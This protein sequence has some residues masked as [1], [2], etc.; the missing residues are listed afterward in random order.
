MDLIESAAFIICLDDVAPTSSTA[1]ANT[2]LLDNISNRWS[3]KSLQFVICRNGSSALLCEHSMVDGST[4]RQLNEAIVDAIVAHS[5]EPLWTGAV[6]LRNPRPVVSKHVFDPIPDLGFHI[7]RVQRKNNHIFAFPEHK[8][9]LST[10]FGSKLL[11]SKKCSPKSGYQLVIQ[12]ASL[13]YFGYQPPSW[14]TISMRTFN[15][16]RVEIMQVVS[17]AVAEFCAAANSPD[18]SISTRRQLFYEAARAHTKTATRVARGRGFAGHLYALQEVLR[19]GEDMPALFTDPTYSRTQPGKIMT[20][21]TESEDA[22]QEGGFMMPDWEHV[23]VR[24]Q[25]QEDG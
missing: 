6:D 15:K 20:D 3:D 4:Y 8:H 11:R 23:W 12:L 5:S 17:P 16:G 1:R 7:N 25:V 14:E 18:V 19:E 10:R 13:L 21:C 22:L 9:H 2:F 24:C